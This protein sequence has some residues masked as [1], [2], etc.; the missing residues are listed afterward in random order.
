LSWSADPQGRFSVALLGSFANRYLGLDPL[1]FNA[2]LLAALVLVF[3]FST[4]VFVTYVY[5]FRGIQ[6]L[7]AVSAIMLSA[8]FVQGYTYFL[9]GQIS[10]LPLFLL[11]LAIAS[12]LMNNDEEGAL[13]KNNRWDFTAIILL[14]NCL[15]VFYAILAFFAMVIIGIALAVRMYQ[16]YK[17]ASKI[18]YRFGCVFLGF[19]LIFVLARILSVEQTISS[20]MDWI[21]LS[22]K[23]ASASITAPMVFSEYLTEGFLGLFFGVFN[24]PINAS[25]F[26]HFLPNNKFYNGILLSIGIT[27][28]ICIT[29]ATTKFI[30]FSSKKNETTAIVIALV[31]T[32][33]GC[34]VA[35]FITKSG[36]AIFKIGNWL[37]PLI[38]PLFIGAIFLPRLSS[39]RMM[40]NSFS[41]LCTLIVFMNMV[42]AASYLYVYFPGTN[43]NAFE[44]AKGINGSREVSILAKQF[45]SN[46]TEKFILDMSDGIKNA[47]AAN[48]FRF[49]KLTPLTHNLQPLADRLPPAIPCEHAP[50]FSEDM[51]LINERSNIAIDVTHDFKA[52]APIASTEHYAVYNTAEIETYTFIGQGAYPTEHISDKISEA[53][54]FPKSF[55]WVEK[56]VEIFVYSHQPKLVN[57]TIKVLPGYVD[58]PKDRKL[59]ISYEK[60]NIT[61]SFSK[62]HSDIHLSD[63]NLNSGLN[64]FYLESEDK[65]SWPKRAQALIRPD[66]PL[67]FR[68]LNFALGEFSIQK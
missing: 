19:I 1:H 62:E 3:S 50:A 24:Y 44:N 9:L 26:N 55:R 38:M 14:L 39:S 18:I 5:R 63:V 35:F 41:A 13:T 22:T 32:A 6:W 21:H 59:S 46:N 16:D 37:I 56:G 31:I 57:I 7:L 29:W 27:I 66:I 65:V 42:A 11:T 40:N 64:C 34:G 68:L 10:A 20:I 12:R 58:G 60:K 36:Y 52:A 51:L 4:G 61:S 30:K 17:S 45:H 2:E 25:F 28:L 33:I 54:G 43:Y 53:T 49:A 67:D 23:T 47:W 15:Y 48:E 8:G